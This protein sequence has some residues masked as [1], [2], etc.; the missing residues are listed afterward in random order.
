[1]PGVYVAIMDENLKPLPVGLP[2]EVKIKLNYSV[3]NFT[4]PV[5]CEQMHFHS[6]RDS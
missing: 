4:L 6:P 1:M 5:K 2:G 3:L